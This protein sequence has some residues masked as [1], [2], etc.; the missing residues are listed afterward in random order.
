MAPKYG[1]TRRTLG[2]LGGGLAATSAVSN[3]AQARNGIDLRHSTELVSNPSGFFDVLEPFSGATKAP[4]M[5]VHGGGHTGSC[6]LST[7]DGRPGWAQYFATRGHKVLVPDWPGTGRSGHVPL[8]RLTGELVCAGLGNLLKSLDHPAI[9]VTHSMSGPYGWKLLET[10][11]E[12]I[13]AVVGVAPGGPGNIQPIGEILSRDGDTIEVKL[14]L[15]MK[16]NVKELVVAPKGWAEKKLI[17]DGTR[18]PREHIERYLA[19]LIAVPP[20]LLYERV[21]VADSQ[22]KVSSFT[23]YKNKRM[24]V[25]VGTNDVDHPVAVDQPIVDWLNTNGAKAD[26]VLLSDVGISG[27]GHMMMLESNS[28]QIAG[29]IEEWIGRI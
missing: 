1:I 21:N 5:L 25:V 14:Q 15:T 12:R 16:L 20:R 22:L 26:F 18:F 9:L 13:K 8:D 27:N 11:G 3:Q 29:F 17:G 2:R 7:A 19:S 6:Y 10:H 23:S 4:M 24:M 28:D